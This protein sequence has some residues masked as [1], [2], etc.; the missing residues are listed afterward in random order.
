MIQAQELRIGNWVINYY[1]IPGILVSIHEGNSYRVKADGEID[2][3]GEENINPIPLTR[4]ILEKAGFIDNEIHLCDDKYIWINGHWN[5]WHL[6]DGGEKDMFDL[7]EPPQYLHQL[8]NLYFALTGK[9]LTIQ[10]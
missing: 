10:L 4:E 7:D 5:T 9:E 6:R 8:Q 1:G 3:W 2:A